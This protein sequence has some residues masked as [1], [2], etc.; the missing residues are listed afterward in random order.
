M[1]HWPFSRVLYVGFEN[2]TDVKRSRSSDLSEDSEGW[3]GFH[4]AHAYNIQGLSR[5]SLANGFRRA[6]FYDWPKTTTAQRVNPAVAY[7]HFTPSI[8]TIKLNDERLQS[9][10]TLYLDIL[11]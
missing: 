8:F 10:R 6:A 5:G 2:D 1:T 3:W 4:R 9:H 11:Y 7:P